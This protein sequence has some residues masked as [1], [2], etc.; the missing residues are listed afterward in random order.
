[1]KASTTHIEPWNEKKELNNI[2]IK[3]SN[4]ELTIL[5]FVGGGITIPEE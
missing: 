1:V 4:A 5:M 2:N 3:L